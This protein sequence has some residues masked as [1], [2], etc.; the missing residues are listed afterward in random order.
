MEGGGELVKDRIELKLQ[1]PKLYS[2]PEILAITNKIPEVSCGF[3]AD[4]FVNSRKYKKTCTKKRK[5]FSIE[6]LFSKCKEILNGKLHFLC[7][8][9]ILLII[10]LHLFNHFFQ[11]ASPQSFFHTT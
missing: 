1:F 5:M 3:L 7:S 8:E 9:K 4:L 10:I 6:D 11:K 2:R